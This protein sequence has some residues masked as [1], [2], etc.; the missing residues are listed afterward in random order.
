VVLKVA[1]ED[2]AHKTDIGGVALNLPDSQ[3]VREAYQRL[4]ANVQQHAPQAR[5]DG[6][7]VAPMLGGGVELIT[8]VSRDPVFGPVVMV[9][10]G[11]V[12]AEVLKDVA[13][14][15]APVSEDE[16]M[17]MLRSL[18]MF[19]VLDGA[20]GQARADV[21]AAAQAVSRLSAFACR[22][23]ADVAE[24]DVNPLLVKP[25]GEGVW[26]LDALMV[27]PSTPTTAS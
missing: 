2:I 17:V 5:L 25:E 7:L 13:V 14:Q 11:G 20:R 19:P 10:F 6:V 21:R 8:G 15:V 12:Y 3:A 23:A 22:H 9:G 4:L 24:I 26:V 16:A 1:S 18:K 27:P